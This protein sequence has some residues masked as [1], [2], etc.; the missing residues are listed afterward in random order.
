MLSNFLAD[1]RLELKPII[2]QCYADLLCFPVSNPSVDSRKFFEIP[3]SV[4]DWDHP[5]FVPIHRPEHAKLA[6]SD[7]A[8]PTPRTCVAEFVRAI[9]GG[10]HYGID[11]T[12]WT[13]PGTAGR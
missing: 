2:L 8:N 1:I 5:V 11:L 7:L 10:G 13:A 6:R 9:A 4:H 3:P 12:A